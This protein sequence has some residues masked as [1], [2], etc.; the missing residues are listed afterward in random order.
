MSVVIPIWLRDIYAKV[1]SS[2]LSDVIGESIVSGVTED[3]ESLAVAELSKPFPET[4]FFIRGNELYSYLA[5]Y[6]N[7]NVCNHVVTFVLVGLRD[8]YSNQRHKLTVQELAQ[9]ELSMNR[10]LPQFYSIFNYQSLSNVGSEMATSAFQLFGT[11]TP[12]S[13]V[14]VPVREF[15][16]AVNNKQPISVLLPE[17]DIIL[18]LTYELSDFWDP[19]TKQLLTNVALRC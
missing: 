13:V 7:A 1:E 14:H 12:F 9:L 8:L 18:S 11:I 5:R 10:P 2:L 15:V 19:L 4:M 3:T 16:N 17:L 6:L